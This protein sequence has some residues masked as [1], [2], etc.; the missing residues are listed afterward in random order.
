MKKSRNQVAISYVKSSR[1]WVAVSTVLLPWHCRGAW[2]DRP[3]ETM[4]FPAN[5]GGGRIKSYLDLDCRRY[6][7]ERDAK[8]GHDE[9]VRA[10][11]KVKPNRV[12]PPINPLPQV[13]RP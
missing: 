9:V 3:F 13:K 12:P 2:A 5:P 6:T 8:A 1:G 11:E 7:M 10:W 4:V